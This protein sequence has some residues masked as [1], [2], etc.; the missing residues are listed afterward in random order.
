MHTHLHTRMADKQTRAKDALIRCMVKKYIYW[1]LCQCRKKW[2]L[3]LGF[4]TVPQVNIPAAV[5]WSLRARFRAVHLLLMTTERVAYGGL[6]YQTRAQELRLLLG[7][8]TSKYTCCTAINLDQ[9]PPSLMWGSVGEADS[10]KSFVV[11]LLQ[12]PF[13]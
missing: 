9:S 4:V 6:W 8:T 12:I 7:H 13:Q 11:I 2:K 5:C 10:F 1:N 3:A